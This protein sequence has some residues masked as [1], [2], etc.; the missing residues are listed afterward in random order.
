MTNESLA[1]VLPPG[2]FIREEIETRGWTQ[3]DL[4]TIL[5]RPLTAV[6]QI[7]TGRRA[8]TPETAKALAE[9]FGTS[10]EFWMNLE[11]QYQLS[12]VP[13]PQGAVRARAQ[14]FEKPARADWRGAKKESP[15]RSE[16]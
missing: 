13:G 16:S 15:K 6:N 14:S 4:A 11:T 8:I 1:V 10:A 5:G 7:I 2:E 9:A 3:G 12:R